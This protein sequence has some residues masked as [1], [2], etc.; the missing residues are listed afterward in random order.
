MDWTVPVLPYLFYGPCSARATVG[1]AV[2]AVVPLVAVAVGDD[3]NHAVD[4]L[5]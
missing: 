4:G 3:G 2:L 1:E 5:A